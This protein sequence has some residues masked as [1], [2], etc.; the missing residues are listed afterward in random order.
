MKK[1]VNLLFVFLL[2]ATASAQTF[3]GY[4]RIWN[5][6]SKRYLSLLDNK[7]WARSSTG[8]LDYDLYAIRTLLDNDTNNL[9]SNPASVILISGTTNN[10]NCGAQGT[11][12]NDITSHTFQIRQVYINGKAQTGKYQLR[13]EYSNIGA[14]VLY[15]MTMVGPDLEDMP[16]SG[17]V[18]AHSIRGI[19]VARSYWHLDP[20]SSSSSC[21]FGFS[22]KLQ[23]NGKYYQTFY[24]SFPFKVVSSGLTIYYVSTL[25]NGQAVLKPYAA[26][27]VIPAETPVVVE[28]SSSKAT[29]NRVELLTNTTTAPKDNL[30]K[31]VFFNYTY[32]EINVAPSSSNRYHNNRTAYVP[33]TM[34]LLTVNADGKLVFDKLE[35]GE[36]GYEQYIPANTAYLSVPATAPAE[37]PVMS[38]ADFTSGIKTV[39]TDP[40]SAPKDDAVYTLN[41]I[42]V[43]DPTNLPHGIYI[44][45]GKKVVK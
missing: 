13:A 6:Y 36:E 15:G 11:S 12:L 44:K 39:S 9:V 42:R 14:V 28:A 5:D 41:G 34:R 31:G 23:A 33:S 18:G 27:A 20:I 3:G 19:T 1:L 32:G 22:P 38:F 21:Y 37:L 8:G 35:A 25:F 43:S 4:Y 26:D 2:A 29:D 7:G 17:A 16:D 30:L 24:A 10:Y 45:K 40:S